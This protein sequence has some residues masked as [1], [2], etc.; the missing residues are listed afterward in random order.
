MLSLP[1]CTN[2]FPGIQQVLMRILPKSRSWAVIQ[3]PAP[4]PG[5]DIHRHEISRFFI[6]K[7][8][9]VAGSRHIPGPLFSW[10]GLLIPYFL[11][12]CCIPKMWILTTSSGWKKPRSLNHRV[13]PV[14]RFKDKD[15]LLTLPDTNDSCI[16]Q[17][18]RK[19]KTTQI[20]TNRS[21]AAA[22]C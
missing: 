3:N 16:W 1:E 21:V 18:A 14:K 17:E 22:K 7:S 12:R 5:N 10:V 11:Q 20:W 8:G 19:Q 9:G 13:D 15:P 6:R 2:W 4:K